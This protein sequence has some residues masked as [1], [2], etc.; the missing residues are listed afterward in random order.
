MQ[1]FFSQYYNFFNSFLVEEKKCTVYVEQAIYEHLKWP[2]ISTFTKEQFATLHTLID[3]IICLGGDGTV[4]HTAMQFPAAVP[5]ILAFNMGTLG[6]LTAFEIE[7]YREYISKVFSG[8][9]Y[10]SIRMRLTCKIIRKN[11]SIEPARM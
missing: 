10:L 4:L 2:N 9:V 11:G 8:R 5:P 7:K 3:L 6:F 1:H